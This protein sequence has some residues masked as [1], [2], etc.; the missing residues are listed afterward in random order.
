MGTQN[1]RK[2]GWRWKK[3]GSRIKV[4]GGSF[5]QGGTAKTGGALDT[6][7]K[8]GPKNHAMGR[9]HCGDQKTEVGM[10]QRKMR[11]VKGSKQRTRGGGGVRHGRKK[12]GRGGT[13][14]RKGRK[15]PFG[16]INEDRREGVNRIRSGKKRLKP[17]RERGEVPNGKKKGLAEG[18]GKMG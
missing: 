9:V 11:A 17:K 2:G 4:R 12:R 7:E 13:A 10:R 18:G 6:L 15:H 16:R 14:C 5:L 1:L 3:K 8:R